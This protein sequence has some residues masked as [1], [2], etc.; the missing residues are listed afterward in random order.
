[1]DTWK[2]EKQGHDGYVWSCQ[3]GKEA[4]SDQETRVYFF[5]EHTAA[6]STSGKARRES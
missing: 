6:S 3:E 4:R 1:M 5:M 2:G